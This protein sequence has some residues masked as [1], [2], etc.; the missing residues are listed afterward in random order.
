[1]STT[2]AGTGHRPG[3]L[4]P[5]PFGGYSD[6]TF[7]KLVG[8]AQNWLGGTTFKFPVYVL[9]GMALGWDQALAQATINIRKFAG[10]DLFLLGCVIPCATQPKKWPSTCQERWQRILDQADDV[11]TISEEY[12]NRCMQDRNEFMVD[13]ATRILALYDGSR[14][15]GTANCIRYAN[16]RGVPVTNL[17]DKWVKIR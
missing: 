9:S 17:W 3:K 16:E 15:G 8:L 10:A 14:A 11:C 5:G 1:M 6:A 2:I 4:G 13:R 12:H 7:D